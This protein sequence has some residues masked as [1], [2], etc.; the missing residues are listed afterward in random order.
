M[1]YVAVRGG[2]KAIEAS[3]AL[4]EHERVRSSAPWGTED[5]EGTF[6]ELVD[7]VMG[8]ASLY[9]PRLAALALK[10]AQ[11]SPDEAVF[12]LRAFRSTL[13]RPYVSRPVDTGRMRVPA[14]RVG[15][16]Q[17]R[18]R[19]PAARRHAR[20]QPSAAGVR[21]GNRRPRGAGREARRADERRFAE[22]AREALR[23]AADG[24][25]ARAGLPA[26]RRAGFPARPRRR[27]RPWTPPWR[28]CRSPR[29]ARCGCK[30]SRAA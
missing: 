20:L 17:G 8:E 12:L 11:G 24:A 7:Q 22:A 2:G 6:P 5:I 19:R 15:G 23:R 13:E 16:V 14:A 29:R 9:A 30:R 10:Q 1:G 4:L 26:R 25:A 18:A 3:L 28:R 27:P 21:S